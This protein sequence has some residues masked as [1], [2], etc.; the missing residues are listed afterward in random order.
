ME[1]VH[2]IYPNN[3]I[4]VNKLEYFIIKSFSN[5]KAANNYYEKSI[6]LNPSNYFFYENKDYLFE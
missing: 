4:V 2:K 5:Y 6:K 1:E 3:L